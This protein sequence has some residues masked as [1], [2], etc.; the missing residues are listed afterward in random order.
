M[1]ENTPQQSNTAPSGGGMDG[2]TI[3]IISYI[4]LIGLIVAFVMNQN[5]KD[6]LASYHI[7][8][9]IG[10]ALLGIAIGIATSIIGF[11]SSTLGTM[12]WYV[13]FIGLVILWIL[14]LV[15]A[16]NGEKAPVPIVGEHFQNWFKNI[17]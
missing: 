9:M 13:L 4:T 17:G 5:K 16:L 3:A 2:K 7:R 1:E 12:I 10:L 14:G 15:K 8:Q 11:I 6:D